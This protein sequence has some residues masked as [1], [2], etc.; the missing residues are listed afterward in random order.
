MVKGAGTRAAAMTI[1]GKLTEL[2]SDKV[3]ETC[4]PALLRDLQAA[5]ALVR[6]RRRVPAQRSPF[7]KTRPPELP[8]KGDGR[9]AAVRCRLRLR[10]PARAPSG[11]RGAVGRARSAWPDSGCAGPGPP[12][13]ADPA[14][15]AHADR[16][17]RAALA[18]DR[19]AARYCA[20]VHGEGHH[21]QLENLWR[22]ALPVASPC[23]PRMGKSS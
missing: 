3:R 23:A 6:D 19:P 5:L 18:G 1:L 2:C 10:A 9:V 16:R 22:G 11:G 7:P 4:D 20:H 14:A 15:A 8:P 21:R 13:G 12:A 17:R